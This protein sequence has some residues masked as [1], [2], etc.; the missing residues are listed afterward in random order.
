MVKLVALNGKMNVKV[1]RGTLSI[2]IILAVIIID[3]IIKIAVKTGMFLRESIHVTDWFQIFFI[4]NRGIAW[5]VEFMPQMLLT[6][7]RL[8]VSIILGYLLYKL[9]KSQ[10][11]TGFIACVSL[12][13]GGAFGNIIDN[14]FYGAIFT[15]STVFSKAVLTSFGD[16]YG[17]FFHGKVVDMFYFPLFETT[18]PQWMPFV[19]GESFVFFNAV[20][21]LADAAISCGVIAIILFYA[22]YLNKLLNNEKK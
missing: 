11:K 4:E 20:F 5:G 17:G 3:Q 12:I 9:V 14:I 18:W 8:C 1:N 6:I 10:A 13:L 2:I 22:K 19:G 16:G 7:F 15:E 21:N